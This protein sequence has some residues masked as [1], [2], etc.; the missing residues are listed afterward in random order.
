LAGVDGDASGAHKQGQAVEK[1]GEKEVK[2]AVFFW[3]IF[4]YTVD[5]Y[6]LYAIIIKDKNGHQL[7][8]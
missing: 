3:N 6:Y 1:R 8:Q 2:R 4:A 5:C 7:Q